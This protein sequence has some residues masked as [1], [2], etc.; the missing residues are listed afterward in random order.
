MTII[1]IHLFAALAAL[2]L[3]YV[4]LAREKG[5]RTHKIIGWVWMIA[6]LF[7]TVPSF[8]ITE[9]NPGSWSWIHGLTI[10]TLVSMAVAIVSIRRGKVRAHANAM[11]GTMIGAT[12]AGGFT[13]LPGRM[14]GR[15]LGL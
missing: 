13:L 1:L 2:V 5:T 7:V 11:I 10:V 15:F 12:I 3:G 4:N 14:I 8:A 6:M 9:T